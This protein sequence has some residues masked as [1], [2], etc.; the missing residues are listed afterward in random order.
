MLKNLNL[1]GKVAIVTGGGRGIGRAV[2]LTLAREGADVVVAARTEA[3]I[4]EVADEIRRSGAKSLAIRTDVSA[5]EDVKN[6]VSKTLQT[7]GKVDILVNNAGVGHPVSLT[8]DI[9][10]EEWDRIMSVNLTSVFLCSKAVLK[11]MIERNYGKIINISSIG[12]RTGK[13]G[14]GPYRAAKA[15]VINFTETLADEVKEHGISV[16]TICPSGVDTYFQRSLGA[17][18]SMMMSPDDIAKVV[19]FLASD[20]SKCVRGAA[21]DVLGRLGPGGW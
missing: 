15:A 16:N 8:W 2:A 21:V 19:A 7:F 14:R 10:V 17:D 18:T 6:L 20:D 11:G 13:S 5:E 3:E 9:D 4:N 1:K 12:G